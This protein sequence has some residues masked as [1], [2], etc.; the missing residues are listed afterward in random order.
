VLKKSIFLLFFYFISP[1]VCNAEYIVYKLVDEQ[2]TTIID[3]KEHKKIYDSLMTLQFP[4]NSN[5]SLKLEEKLTSDQI[6]LLNADEQAFIESYLQKNIDHNIYLLWIPQTL[7]ELFAINHFLQHNFK[8]YGWPIKKKL[9]Y[10]DSNQ[11]TFYK[12]YFVL[13]HEI[14]TMNMVSKAHF[15]INKDLFLCLTQHAY[16]FNKDK[17]YITKEFSLDLL[18]KLKTLI[19]AL[20]NP[21]CT[22]EGTFHPSIEYV[23]LIKLVNKMPIFSKV[24]EAEFTAYYTNFFVIYRGT[25]GF[26]N[27]LDSPVKNENGKFIPLYLSYGSGLYA[28]SLADAYTCPAAYATGTNYF[29]ALL[30]NKADYQYNS[31]TLPDKNLV[32]LPPFNSIVT[33]FIGGMH[34]HP[35]AK[36]FFNIEGDYNPYDPN[37]IKFFLS[38]ALNT[39]TCE[40]QFLNYCKTHV[41]MI[42]SKADNI[43]F[44]FNPKK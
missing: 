19:E 34:C 6:K 4:M 14:N 2:P 24:L 13:A 22:K 8:E 35:R 44:N 27:R 28:S 31:I 7:F 39:Q 29:Y 15:L 1:I 37:F 3:E 36:S 33:L 42:I 20:T 11:D 17:K 25:N 10:Y 32:H 38:T 23:D 16:K 40:A 21:T 30:I 26:D 41:H 5:P 12:R 18:N 43:K 9:D